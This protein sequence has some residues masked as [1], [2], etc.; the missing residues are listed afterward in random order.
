MKTKQ[1]VLDILLS[2]VAEASGLT[3]TKEEAISKGQDKYLYLDCNFT[4]GGYSLVM[5]SVETT[6]GASMERLE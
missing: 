2:R 6:A 5:V 1:Q 4:Y 3:D